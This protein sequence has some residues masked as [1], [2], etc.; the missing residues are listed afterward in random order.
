MSTLNPD[1]LNPDPLD[2]S[3]FTLMQYKNLDKAPSP[4]KY[5]YSE[6]EII[7]DLSKYIDRTYTEHYKA[8]DEVE[9]FDA[10]I[11]LGTASG[12]F[13]DTA[14]KYLWRYGKK[15]G[16]NKDDLM[17]ALHYVT[18]LLYNEHYKKD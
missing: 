4:I 6:N 14:L 17:K 9:C 2:T 10:W 5:K 8:E 3:E 13:R 7:S 18:L 15:G 1:M 16:N 11:A 12:T